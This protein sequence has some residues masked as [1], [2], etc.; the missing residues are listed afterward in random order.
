MVIR[1]IIKIDE[2]KCD[3]CGLCI[4]DCAEGALKLVDGLKSAS[5]LSVQLKRRG[6]EKNI[7]Y[8]IR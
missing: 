3:G 7:E 4:V 6:R 5:N 8:N 2:T 1:K